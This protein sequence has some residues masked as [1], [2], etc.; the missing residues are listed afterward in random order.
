MVIMVKKS[1]IV[2]D[3]NI[4]Y[5]QSDNFNGEGVRVFLHGWGSEATLFRKILEKCD[6]FVALD[7]PGFGGS[8]FPSKNWGV[9]EYA[10]FLNNFLTKLEIK[11]PLLIGHSFG[12]SVAIKYN[13]LF[14]GVRKNILIGAAGI[15]EKTLKIKIYKIG[16]KIFK[17]ATLIPGLDLIRKKI[18]NDFYEKIGSLDYINSGKLKESYKKI[19]SEN[20]SEDMKKI[21]TETVLIWGEDDAETLLADGKKI[22]SLIKN[23]KLLMIKNAGHYVFLDQPEKFEELFFQ[24]LC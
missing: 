8:E 1:I 12:G 19:I 20:L 24:E 21:K 11:N 6:N 15:R 5:Y 22:N 16:A 13:V 4:N 18:R 9:S 3:L 10:I 14:G 23:S 17:L 2:D 7:F